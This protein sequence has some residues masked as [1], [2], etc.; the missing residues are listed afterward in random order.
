[1]IDREFVKAAGFALA[2]AVLTFFG[3][4]HS[5]AIGIGKTPMVAL[6]YAVVALALFA[7]ARS[8]AKS[9]QSA[10]ASSEPLHRGSLSPAE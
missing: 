9:P 2:G 7:C 5:E 3:F 4:M 8:A 10:R 6:S 1:M